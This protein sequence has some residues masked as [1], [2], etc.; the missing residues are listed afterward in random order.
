MLGLNLIFKKCDYW[1]Q[2]FKIKKQIQQYKIL[3]KINN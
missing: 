1:I 2:T 3:Q